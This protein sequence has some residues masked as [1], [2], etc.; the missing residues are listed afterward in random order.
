MSSY[1]ITLRK[2]ISGVIVPEFRVNSQGCLDA[3]Y[4]VNTVLT[5]V[6]PV[7][8]E[9][10]HTDVCENLA[11]S[12]LLDQSGFTWSNLCKEEQRIGH[13]WEDGDS[14]QKRRVQISA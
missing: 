5:S 14:P 12:S 11:N 7:G 10:L 1:Y 8:I 6:A 2:Q 3:K 9:P 13:L 4:P